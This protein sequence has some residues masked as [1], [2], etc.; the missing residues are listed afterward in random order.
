MSQSSETSFFSGRDSRRERRIVDVLRIFQSIGMWLVVAMMM[1]TMVHAIGRYGFDRPIAGLSEISVSML[2]TLVFLMGAYT[3][4]VKG[5]ISIGIIVDRFSARTQ[6]I[7]D[8]VTYI[9][10]LVGAI[11][12]LSQS[13]VRGIYTIGGATSVVL[14]IPVFPFLFIVA[15]GWAIF[16]MVIVM[17]LI[18]FLPKAV[19]R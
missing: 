16:G 9:L 18:H 12:G 1:V 13:I 2:V 8:S 3:A 4:V 19:K 17:H 14:A 7:I 6:A 11:V 15:F 5:H 10:C